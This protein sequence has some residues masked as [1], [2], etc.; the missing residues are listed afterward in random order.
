MTQC[1]W[2]NGLWHLKWWQCLHLQGQAVF[3]DTSILKSKV[4]Q[5][6]KYHPMT[7][8]HIQEVLNPWQH[9]HEKLGSHIA[10]GC[11]SQLF[12]KRAQT[13]LTIFLK[14]WQL[15]GGEKNS[16]K[17]TVVLHVCPWSWA[18][19]MVRMPSTETWGCRAVADNS[20]EELTA[21]HSQ[22]SQSHHYSSHLGMVSLPALESPT[23]TRLKLN[24]MNK[25]RIEWLH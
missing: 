20:V 15:T 22:F 6:L 19:W 16:N 5:T 10:N 8:C 21:H 11:F 17:L 2:V 25:S 18:F 4:L 9:C 13:C 1:C 24:G 14:A 23:Y 12:W 7:Q 3:L